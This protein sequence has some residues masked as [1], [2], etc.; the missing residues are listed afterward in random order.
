GR[1]FAEQDNGALAT[2]IAA[3]IASLTTEAG[4]LQALS[5]ERAEESNRLSAAQRDLESAISG[6]LGAEE[7]AEL[8]VRSSQMG[9]AARRLKQMRPIAEEG[10]RLTAAARETRDA[11]TAARRLDEMS[12]SLIPEIQQLV[13]SVINRPTSSFQTVDAALAEA[14]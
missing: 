4:R 12:T 7:Q 1:D 8:I 5:T 6:K 2:H 3:K 10:E 13:Q 9:E 11:V 14:I